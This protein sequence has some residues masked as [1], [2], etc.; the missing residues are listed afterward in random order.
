MGIIKELGRVRNVSGL[1]NIYKLS[2]EAAGIVNNIAIGDSVAVNG[3]CL[4]LTGKDRNI[5]DFDMKGIYA[6]TGSACTSGSLEPSHVLNAMGV[7]PD[8]AQSSVR[9]SFGYEN[10]EEDVNYCLSE[11]PPIVERLRKM[12]PLC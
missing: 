7:P 6:S 12:S 3:V 11:I 5:L 2:I 9:F 10:T 8:L 4:T 1:G